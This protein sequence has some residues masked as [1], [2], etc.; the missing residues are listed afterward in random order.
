MCGKRK[1]AEERARDERGAG[2]EGRRELSEETGAGR[3]RPWMRGPQPEAPAARPCRA[4]PVGR[5]FSGRGGGPAPRSEA[6]RVGL[7][8]VANSPAGP[9]S[10][11]EFTSGGGA[12]RS[13]MPSSRDKVR[14]RK[15]R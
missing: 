14:G 5:P 9:E 12:D 7:R 6:P 1:K 15:R 13:R 11:N 2:R 10:L 3:E 4:P 8:Q